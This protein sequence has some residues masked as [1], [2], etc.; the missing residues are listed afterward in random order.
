MFFC[1]LNL[2]TQAQGQPARGPTCVCLA[3]ERG[4]RHEWPSGTVYPNDSGSRG[5]SGLCACALCAGVGGPCC[6]CPADAGDSSHAARLGS[7]PHLLREINGLVR[8]VPAGRP[9]GAALRSLLI[10]QQRSDRTADAA[11]RNETPPAGLRGAG[12]AGR[13]GT[14][15]CVRLICPHAPRCPA[16]RTLNRTAGMMPPRGPAS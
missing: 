13:P 7:R 4:F 14:A 6:L 11:A 1:S 8:G 9:G 2:T 5:V 12:T 3:S 15:T 10:N 16:G